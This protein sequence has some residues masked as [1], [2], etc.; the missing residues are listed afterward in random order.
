[1][2]KTWAFSL[3]IGVFWLYKGLLHQKLEYP[4]AGPSPLTLPPRAGMA[5]H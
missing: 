2:G 1:M 4:R 5:H 3:P